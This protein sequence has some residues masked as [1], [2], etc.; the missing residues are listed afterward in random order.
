MT[1]RWKPGTDLAFEHFAER[2]IG[3]DG[4]DPIVRCLFGGVIFLPGVAQPLLLKHT[5]AEVFGNFHGAV[6]GAGIDH[7][8]LIG[9]AQAFDGTGNIALLVVGDDGC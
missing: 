6:A 8:N 4:Q 9:R 2:F 3:I 7:N 1:D 5:H